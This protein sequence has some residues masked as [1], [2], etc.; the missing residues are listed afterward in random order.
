MNAKAEKLEKIIQELKQVST[1]VDAMLLGRDGIVIAPGKDK[2]NHAETFAASC[3]KMTG[4]ADA[5]F[6]EFTKVGPESVIVQ[7]EESV[8]II[9]DAGPK[10]VLMVLNQ[11]YEYTEEMMVLAEM[12]AS[13]IKGLL[14]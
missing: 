8:L 11:G 10:A 2:K 4:E 5:A 6:S 1:V 9:V 14:D 7:G 3:A 12:K 13:R